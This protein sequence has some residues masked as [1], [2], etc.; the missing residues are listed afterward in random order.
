M[1]SNTGDFHPIA[2]RHAARTRQI[3]RTQKGQ[4]GD[5]YDFYA[6]QRQLAD[7][8]GYILLIPLFGSRFL[9]FDFPALPAFKSFDER[10]P[11]QHKND[12]PDL[13]VLSGDYGGCSQNLFSSEKS[14]ADLT[15]FHKGLKDYSQIPAKQTQVKEYE[16]QIDRMV[17]ELYGLTDEEIKIVERETK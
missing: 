8:S 3:R 7:N 2:S 4:Y 13:L 1:G 12:K 14:R 9:E 11:V 6:F 5:V 15:P 10:F 16:R 17:Y